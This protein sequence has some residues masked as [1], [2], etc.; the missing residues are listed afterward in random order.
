[1][2]RKQVLHLLSN[3]YFAYGN[4]ILAQNAKKV[5]LKRKPFLDFFHLFLGELQSTAIFPSFIK[6]F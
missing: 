2:I 3:P 6:W 4:Y 1:M 5:K